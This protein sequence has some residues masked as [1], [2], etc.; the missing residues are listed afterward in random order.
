MGNP[1]LTVIVLA[2]NQEQY[3]RQTLNGVL[4]QKVSYD[5]RII[6][7][8]DGSTDN[9]RTIIQSVIDDNPN[10]ISSFFNDVN[11]GLTETLKK[12][13]PSLNTKYACF[14]GGDDYWVDE[15]KLQKQIEILE[16]YQ[17]V[18]FVHTGFQFL[19]EPE[20]V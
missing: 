17:N 6:V 20:N 9:T 18:S 15:Y 2:Y 5:Y 4:S 1:V 3:I 11:L 13:V 8:E 14:L 10:I 7:T 16:K 12:V 19:I